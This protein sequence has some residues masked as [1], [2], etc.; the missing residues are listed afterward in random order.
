MHCRH[1]R[2]QA[3]HFCSPGVGSH[4]GAQPRPAPPAAV[5][6]GSREMSPDRHRY[7]EDDM[8][9]RRNVQ[10][11]ARRTRRDEESRSSMTYSDHFDNDGYPR[12]NRTDRST[13]RSPRSSRPILPTLKLSRTTVPLVSGRF[14]RNLRTVRTTTILTAKRDCV[15]CERAWRARQV[16]CCGMPVSAPQQVISFG[17]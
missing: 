9:A 10:P 16:R 2:K 6:T 11:D 8:S 7:D 17:C 12:R 5:S 14:C 15:T 1:S 3:F 4:V 13:E